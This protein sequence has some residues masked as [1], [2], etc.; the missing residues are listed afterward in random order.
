M[1]GYLGAEVIKIEP[2]GGDPI[3]RWRLLD[4]GGTSYW[5]RSLARNKRCIVIDLREAEGRDLAKA[6][7]LQS[8]VLVENFRPGTME[9]WGLGPEVFA[10][11]K[12]G[13]VYA[14][15]SGYGQTG[16]YRERPGYASV[17]EA[18]GGL[19][20]VTGRPGELPVRSNLS[21][22]DTLAG[23]HTVIGVL[24]ALHARAR[25]GQGQVVD[26]ALYEAVLGA[27]EGVIPEHAGAG[28]VRGPS[29]HT[30]SGIVPTRVS[31]SRSR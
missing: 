15:V 28:A 26:T 30:A 10:A 24:A 23:M 9:A 7:A 13:L 20:H 27:L 2:P 18:V 17:A 4:E 12:P 29:G 21:L 22:G 3:R 1:L 16:P 11:E 25:D 19:R 6:L 31:S 14:R 8:D 5:W